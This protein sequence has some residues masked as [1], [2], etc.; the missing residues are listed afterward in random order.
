[1][2]SLPLFLLIVARRGLGLKQAKASLGEWQVPATFVSCVLAAQVAFPL[3]RW[4]DLPTPKV[5]AN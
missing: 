3:S 4:L 1:M 2:K 5:G